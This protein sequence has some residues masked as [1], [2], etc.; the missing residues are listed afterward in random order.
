[1]QLTTDHKSLWFLVRCN[2]VCIEKALIP[3]WV[4]SQ[5][6][7][8]RFP[9]GV[10]NGV[11][12]SQL[13][14]ESPQTVAV[15]GFSDQ[16]W[17][18]SAQSPIYLCLKECPAHICI[19]SVS[20]LFPLSSTCSV[21]CLHPQVYSNKYSIAV[22][23]AIQFH[24][25]L[26]LVAQRKGMV[27]CMNMAEYFTEDEPVERN[28]LIIDFM[29]GTRFFETYGMKPGQGCTAERLSSYS[30]GKNDVVLPENTARVLF[31]P[32]TNA[33]GHVLYRPFWQGDTIRHT[34]AATVA[35]VKAFS[36]SYPVPL[37]F[38]PILSFT[39]AAIPNATQVL[40]RL[41]DGVNMERFLHEF[42]PWMAKELHHGNLYANNVTSYR[43]VISLRESYTSTPVYHRNLSMAIFFLVNLCLGVAGTFWL[44]TRTRR[45]EVGVLL[46]F[47][48]TSGYI[49]RLLM[50]EGFVLTLV[51]TVVGCL[52]YLPYALLEGLDEGV[53]HIQNYADYWVTNFA[54]HYFIVS[55]V[56]FLLLLVVVLA[57]I[58]IPARNISRIS[59]TDALRDE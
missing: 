31:A 17:I 12:C 27:I 26:C 10:K 41:K 44:Q 57:G 42:R 20:R 54:L 59:P 45:E 55:A 51:A 52:I 39:G 8:A 2:R 34:V 21:V 48:G 7:Y 14:Q 49:S 29:P 3:G 9:R 24:A 37:L 28:V 22:L 5:K 4:L 1:M 43:D 46:S 23:V 53:V 50:G 6:N 38:R 19:R 18:S 30:Y 58:Y 15:L 35:D 33:L 40:V 11:N 32:G 56:V 13:A 36:D 47:G 25:V 16:P